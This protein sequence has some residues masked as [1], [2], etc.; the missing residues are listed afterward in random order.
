[1][2]KKWKYLTIGC[3]IVVLLGIGGAYVF[4]VRGKPPSREP[5]DGVKL[6][7][8][9][10]E[11]LLDPVDTGENREIDEQAAREFYVLCRQVVFP[12]EQP[13]PREDV[14]SIKVE[15]VFETGK[16]SNVMRISG[17]GLFV[18]IKTEDCT[19]LDLQNL[20]P[21]DD[22]NVKVIPI[23]KDE[24]IKKA[25]VL[26]RKLQELSTSFADS[27]NLK[28]P[29]NVGYSITAQ[30]GSPTGVDIYMIDAKRAPKSG[31]PYYMQPA[32]CLM[33][34]ADGL[35]INMGRNDIA[36]DCSDVKPRIK[37][38][39]AASLARGIIVDRIEHMKQV[40]NDVPE[41]VAR[42]DKIKVP[43][44]ATLAYVIPNWNFSDKLAEEASKGMTPII[45]RKNRL[46]WLVR[47]LDGEDMFMEV[48]VDAI[49]GDIIGGNLAW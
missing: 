46:A 19:I 2:I 18:S 21:Y 38:E 35:L 34:R 23:P 8:T 9:E 41:A 37:E 40:F 26:L 4:A 27:H 31:I 25:K 39:Q 22:P 47:A 36:E 3:V 15:K 44:S 11:V 13:I 28:R 33:L 14:A 20:G 45:E 17:P 16:G 29:K 30:R 49:T 24:A 10:G 42:Y 43:T 5:A 48:W 12:E 32:A 1:M 6:V 7:K